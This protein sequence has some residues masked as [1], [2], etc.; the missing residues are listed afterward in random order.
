MPLTQ[1]TDNVLAFDFCA[2]VQRRACL[3]R[4]SARVVRC[5]CLP[6]LTARP[7][8]EKAATEREHDQGREE[9]RQE[10]SRHVAGQPLHR[11]RCV[12]GALHHPAPR[13]LPQLLARHTGASAHA[14]TEFTRKR[15][16]PRQPGQALLLREFIR[17]RR[18]PLVN[19][20]KYFS[21][22]L[23]IE[24]HLTIARVKFL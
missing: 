24:P 6:P 11:V 13:Q 14:S 9:A 5:E 10:E 2:L 3:E 12:W 15:R 17:Q 19:P 23:W 7:C 21:S 8:R 16:V 20:G 18:V 22:G 1:A 4:P